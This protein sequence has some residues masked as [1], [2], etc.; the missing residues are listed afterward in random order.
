M[1]RSVTLVI[2]VGNFAI[3]STVAGLCGGIHL[4][5]PRQAQDH[6]K[7][8]V[9]YRHRNDDKCLAHITHITTGTS[10]LS[11]IY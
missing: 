10:L 4:P 11:P 9:M 8:K 3:S 6:V 1:L 7:V 5:R 2:I